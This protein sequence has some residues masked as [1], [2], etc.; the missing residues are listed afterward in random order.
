MAVDK[1]VDSTQLNSDL[2][3]VANAIRAKGGTSSSLAFPSG[4]VNAVNTIDTSGT[5]FVVTLTYNLLTEIYEPDC[6]YAELYA[7]YQAGKN[8]SFE[9]YSDDRTTSQTQYAKWYF[10]NDTFEYSIADENGDGLSEYWVKTYFYVFSSNGVTVKPYQYTYYD[11]SDG[12]ALAGNVLSGKVFYNDSGRSVGTM[13]LGTTGTPIATKGTVSNHSI[14]VTPSVTNTTGYITGSTINGT[15]VS[16][17]ASELVSGTKSITANGTGIDVTN[18]ANVDVTITPNYQQKTVNPSTSTQVIT[19]DDTT[20]YL[21]EQFSSAVSIDG[22]NDIK[23]NITYD[24]VP[25]VGESCHATVNW[26]RAGETYSYDGNFQWPQYGNI[27]F[28]VSKTGGSQ[29]CAVRFYS[30]YLTIRGS[31]RD[32]TNYPLSITLTSTIS[33][34]ALSQVTVNAMPNGSATTPATTITANPSI[35]VGNDGLITASVSGTQSV[36]PTVSAGYVASGTAGTI[37]VSGSNT[38]QLTTQAAQTITPTTTNQTIA[39]GTYLTG[40]QT[41]SGDANLIPANI[42]SGISIFGVNGTHSGGG[43]VSN[44]VTGTFK[45]TTTG[46]AMD[47]TVPYTG[48]GYPIVLVIFVTGGTF[49]G[50]A[51]NNFYNLIQRYACASYS[52]I[53]C[54]TNLASS[55]PNADSS[56]NPVSNKASVTQVYKSSATSAT[57]YSTAGNALAPTYQKSDASSSTKDLVHIKNNTTFSAFIADTSYGFAANFEYT[58]Y[59]IYSS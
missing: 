52:I 49:S 21:D 48:D 10:V 12:D 55:Y 56:S 24:E 39:S 43:G 36:T 23:Y 53:K 46:A 29:S 17:S 57:L 13:P 41:I 18:Y 33:Y 20:T 42:A 34:D 58:Y 25:T 22:N 35:T 38:S 8:I 6:T 51:D 47:I 37:T 54:R 45:G 16:V 19:A 30:T 26:T 3:S 44:V 7:A 32:G 40:A 4:F 9:V 59:V 2:T 31:E 5:D 27:A 11:S 1:L 50:L 28:Y 14:S 15:A